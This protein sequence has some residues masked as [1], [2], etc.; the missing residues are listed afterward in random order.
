MLQA[1]FLLFIWL[2]DVLGSCDDEFD[3]FLKK[4]VTKIEKE[5]RE[6]LLGEKDSTATTTFDPILVTQLLEAMNKKKKEKK[7]DAVQ[8]SVLALILRNVAYRQLQG[9]G[10]KQASTPRKTIG[11][12]IKRF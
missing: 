3:E 8:D 10:S 12:P 7:K 5:F 4:Q 9:K 2:F 6:Q 1:T 11:E